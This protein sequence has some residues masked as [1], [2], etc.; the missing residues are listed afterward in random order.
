MVQLKYFNV[1]SDN[2]LAPAR[3]MILNILTHIWVTRPQWVIV[4]INKVIVDRLFNALERTFLFPWPLPWSIKFSQ[5]A[6]FSALVTKSAM[7]REQYCASPRK[8]F[9]C[10]WRRFNFMQS[11]DFFGSGKTS[12]AQTGLRRTQTRL[13]LKW[14]LLRLR[15]KFFPPRTVQTRLNNII[16]FPLILSV[17]ENI[18]ADI[19]NS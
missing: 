14:H 1:G 6:W 7:N 9:F 12:S 2:G 8:Q 5:T 10:T 19:D 4:G 17:N 15:I 11:W 13:L 16:I 3:P 18:V